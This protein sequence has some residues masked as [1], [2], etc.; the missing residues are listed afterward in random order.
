MIRPWNSYKQNKFQI[1]K[2][3]Q[4]LEGLPV[5]VSTQLQ[6]NIMS[7]SGG[8][9]ARGCPKNHNNGKNPRVGKS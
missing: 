7:D 6:V 1:I 4:L 5:M 9:C 8:K 3:L 2:L